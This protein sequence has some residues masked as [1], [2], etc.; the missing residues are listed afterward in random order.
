[1]YRSF[2]FSDHCIKQIDCHCHQN[3]S[4]TLVCGSCATTLFLPHFDV[5]F[6]LLLNRRTAMESVCYRDLWQRPITARV[7]FTTL[8][9]PSVQTATIHA[10]RGEEQGH[11]NKLV[12]RVTNM[13]ITIITVVIHF[14]RRRTKCD[15]PAMS[16]TS[17]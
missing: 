5:L 13:I 15:H 11:F 10:L 2:F 1:M 6:D 3:I 7:I 9:H 16:C 4:D 14:S 8:G 12:A 17:Y